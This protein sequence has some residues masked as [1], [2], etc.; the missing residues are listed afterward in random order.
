MAGSWKL[1]NFDYKDSDGRM[2]Y[3]C[4]VKR[5]SST[6]GPVCS[7]ELGNY[8]ILAVPEGETEPWVAQIVGLCTLSATALAEAEEPETAERCSLRWLYRPADIVGDEFEGERMPATRLGAREVC[9]TDAIDGPETNSLNCIDEVVKIVNRESDLSGD[10][11]EA[12]EENSLRAAYFC[13]RYAWVPGITKPVIE[14]MTFKDGQFWRSVGSSEF[15]RMG[16]SPST[17]GD[18]FWRRWPTSTPARKSTGPSRVAKGEA[19][20]G[21]DVVVK[22]EETLSLG[23]MT[24]ESVLSAEQLALV[25]DRIAALTDEQLEI[26]KANAPSDMK[27]MLEMFNDPKEVI[28]D[29]D[30]FDELRDAAVEDAMKGFWNAEALSKR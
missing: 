29:A 9:F 18:L 19:H 6:T 22:E 17:R 4:A 20:H 26:V 24:L 12:D 7:V 21:M 13:R 30:Q 1:E 23:N 14:W 25:R 10:D 16:T 27:H 3:K 15:D 8:V 11:W 28:E 5:S 2:L